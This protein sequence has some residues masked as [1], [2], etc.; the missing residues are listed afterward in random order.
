MI[1]SPSLHLRIGETASGQRGGEAEV[2]RKNLT[3]RPRRR[4]R[5]AFLRLSPSPM[6]H[7]RRVFHPV[8]RQHLLH[9][10]PLLRILREHVL[11]EQQRVRREL[12]PVL[13]DVLHRTIHRVVHQLGFRSA[14]EGRVAH[15]Q[16]EQRHA[17]R[18]HVRLRRV[19]AALRS[20]HALSPTVMTS[21]AMY[22][23]VPTISLP[24]TPDS[25]CPL[26]VLVEK[27]RENAAPEV[28]ELHF[29]PLV[30]TLENDVLRLDVQV[31]DA[32]LVTRQQAMPDLPNH[33]RRFVLG[34]RTV[35]VDSLAKIA[36]AHVLHHDIHQIGI[37][38]DV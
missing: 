24:V 28:G 3:T 31:V 6:P 25:R 11:H 15:Q 27:V 13:C 34:K 18:E 36:A 19:L 14:L 7:R 1:H 29:G 38:V 10:R 17:Q 22:P 4:Q 30:A 32:L 12:R 26:R 2:R 21:G 35:A 20:I 16:E 5:A 37:F 9:R 8:E 23:A 33:T